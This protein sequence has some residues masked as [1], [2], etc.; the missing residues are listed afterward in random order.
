M[1]LPTSLLRGTAGSALDISLKLSH[2]IS[3]SLASLG[4]SDMRQPLN[5][6]LDTGGWH[7]C[8]WLGRCFR[9][10]QA[11]ALTCPSPSHLLPFP[12]DTEQSREHEGL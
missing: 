10:Q 12:G 4:V 8:Y 6:A 9:R 3:H 5:P 2:S 11:P 7:V 1:H